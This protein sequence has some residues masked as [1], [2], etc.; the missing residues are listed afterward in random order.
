MS[1]LTKKEI[2]AYIALLVAAMFWGTTFVAISSTNDYFPPA[3]LV[4][5]RCAIGGVVL[6][7]VFI[8]RLKHLSRSYII[9][10]AFLGLL[11]TIGYLMQNL[12]IAAGCPPGRCGFLVA[13]YCVITP[14]IAW[15][16]WKRKPNVYNIIAAVLCLVGIGFISMPDLLKTSNVGLNLGDFLAL[17]GSVIFAAYL[18]YLGRYVDTMDPILLTIGNLFFGVIYAGLYT[19]FFEDSTR[20][21]W[22]GQSIFAAL[23]L[24]VICMSLTNILQAIGQREVVASTAALI[25]S[26]E[27]V[28]GIILA[29]AFWH[30]KVTAALLI[31]CV[32]IFIA[33]VISETKLG[34]LK[35]KLSSNVF[36]KIFS[37]IKAKESDDR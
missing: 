10:C 12:S 14:F 2:G 18:V 13:T 31:G 28:F 16:V 34:F 22:N 35:K 21:V 6:L 3:F 25:F 8:K 32:F 19:Y 7:F 30:E 11:M 4:F 5:M 27:S 23:Y 37:Q 1:K 29:I 24:G 9:V 36:R 20:I 33:I 17:I 26:L 15:F